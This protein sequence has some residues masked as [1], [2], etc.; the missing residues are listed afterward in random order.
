M[1]LSCRADALPKIAM[2]GGLAL[3]LTRVSAFV[4]GSFVAERLRPDRLQAR[5]PE[6]ASESCE[7][8]SWVKSDRA[9]LTWTAPR[10]GVTGPIHR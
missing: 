1:A 9:C 10:A 3:V 4:L 7:K 2:D 8:Q 5:I 6:P